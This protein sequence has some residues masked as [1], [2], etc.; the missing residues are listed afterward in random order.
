MNES[1]AQCAR[2]QS[3]VSAKG[4]WDARAIPWKQQSEP[5][6]VLIT[7][8]EGCPKF[9]DLIVT[10][11]WAPL[12]LRIKVRLQR[13]S[14]R[15][16]KAL[17]D[18]GTCSCW[19]PSVSP[20]APPEV[21][22]QLPIMSH[23]WQSALGGRYYGKPRVPPGPQ[24]IEKQAWEAR[25]LLRQ[26]TRTLLQVSLDFDPFPTLFVLSTNWWWW[27]L[28]FQT[29]TGEVFCRVAVAVVWSKPPSY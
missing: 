3:H 17:P 28:P 11:E 23:S 22:L 16:R 24:S 21:S 1:E 20:G 6:D 12:F 7:R 10:L 15:L 29:L 27:W 26:T 2:L 8:E 19:K 9:W 13:R 4:P 14:E 18:L 5:M 25:F